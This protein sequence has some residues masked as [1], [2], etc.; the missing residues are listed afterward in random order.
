VIA[1]LYI[2]QNEETAGE[3]KRSF[4]SFHNKRK[5][6]AA[7]YFSTL[8]LRLFSFFSFRFPREQSLLSRGTEMFYD[9]ELK[10]RLKT[11]DGTVSPRENITSGN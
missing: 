4:S 9:V 5:D 7:F 3:T 2:K 8:I 10:L 6:Y 11:I 1:P